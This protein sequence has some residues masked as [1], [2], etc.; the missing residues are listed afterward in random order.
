MAVQQ[1]GS[2]TYRSFASVRQVARRFGASPRTVRRLRRVARRH[3]L[4]A[5]LDRWASSRG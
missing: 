2:A 3:G 1:P 4:A 5:R